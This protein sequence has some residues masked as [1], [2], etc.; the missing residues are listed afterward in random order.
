MGANKA[1]KAHKEH[2][3]EQYAAYDRRSVEEEVEKPPFF[4]SW[5][6]LYAFVL[7]FFVLLVVLFYIFTKWYE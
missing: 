1:H 5:N 6:R 7:G 3:E 4:S 2:V